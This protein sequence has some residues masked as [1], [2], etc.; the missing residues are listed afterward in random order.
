MFSVLK[1][2]FWVVQPDKGDIMTEKDKTKP[3]SSISI[4][5]RYFYL[6]ILSCNQCQK[7]PFELVSTERE[8][9]H[10][11][12]I[13]YVRCRQCQYGQRLRFDRTAL[14]VDEVESAA[15]TLPEVN[16]TDR[17]SQLIDLGQWLA[18]FHHILAKA[19][20]EK[21]RKE[22][23]RLGYEAT[24]CLEEALKFYTPDSDLPPQEAFWTEA[25][26]KRLK[27]HPELFVRQRLL[28][29]REKLP[30]L[31]VMRHAMTDLPSYESN[32]GDGEGNGKKKSPWWKKW[33]KKD[34]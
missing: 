33:F 20:E 18:L 13:W 10:P 24:L 25:S 1:L 15:G 8:P 30:S 7:G 5:E 9:E 16:P 32:Q 34:G 23:Q 21:D 26:Q 19:S 6:M 4:I 2:M 14:R 27:E 11:I 3:L 31:Q 29:M 22:A 28:Q 12:D 17:P